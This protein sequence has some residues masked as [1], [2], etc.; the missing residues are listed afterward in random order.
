MA[1]PNAIPEVATGKRRGISIVWIVPIVAAAI[2]GYLAFI[3]ITGKGPEIIISFET[4]D[5]LEAGKTK[6]KF[7]DVEVGQVDRIDIKDDLSGVFVTATLGKGAA[8]FLTDKTRFWVVRPRIG[9]GEISGLGT[10]VSGAYIEIDP[11]DAGQSTKSFLGLETPP[12]VRSDDQGKRFDL[13]AP[14]L[15]SFSH[16]SPVFYRGFEAGR[17]VGFGLAEDNRSVDVQ[18]FVDAPYDELVRKNSRFWNVSGIEVSLDA[19][20]MSVQTESLV[21]IIEGGIAFDTPQDLV[22]APAADDGASFPLF[23]SFEEVEESQYRVAERFILY[24]DGSVRGLSVGAPVEVRGVKVGEVVDVKVEFNRETLGLRAPVL[25]TLEA[26]RLS[27]IG[28]V[29]RNTKEYLQT[30][31]EAGFRAQLQ[32]GSLITGALLVSLDFYPDQPARLV[33]GDDRYLEIPTIPS[34]LEQ[35]TASVSGVLST[36]ASLPL[37]ELIEDMRTTVQSANTVISSPELKRSLA[38]LDSSLAQM[39]DILGVVDTE[40]EPLLQSLRATSDAAGVAAE[41]AEETLASA[42]SMIGENSQLRHDLQQ[43]LAQLAAAA[44]SI[45]VL[46]DYL[47]SHPEALISGKRGAR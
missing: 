42:E 12:L 43:M 24:F 46:A 7:R 34:E 19:D 41:Q 44:R 37:R 9:A 3:T 8:P 14:S 4:A 31:I 45:R 38:S 33:G 40:A 10:L 16:G 29:P 5:G 36:L 11:S 13:T 35:L 26:G 23:D 2:A 28:E 27:T 21:S 47:E 17:I 25:I 1:D 22:K 18:I 30:M 39:D 6:I 15:G 32:S 20:G